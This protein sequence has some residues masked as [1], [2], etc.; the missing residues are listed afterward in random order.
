MLG[1]KKY[2]HAPKR[3]IHEIPVCALIILY[4][5]VAVIA[6][7]GKLTNVPASPVLNNKSTKEKGSNIKCGSGNHT[8]PICSNPG[9]E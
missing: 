4:R 8:V 3:A 1:F 5:I 7:L 9:L 2:R 6:I